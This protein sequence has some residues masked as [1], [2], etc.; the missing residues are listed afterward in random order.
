IVAATMWPPIPWPP[1]SGYDK[2]ASPPR[3]P[4]GRCASGRGRLGRIPA[5]SGQAGLLRV[6]VVTAPHA[7]T[8]AVA[9]AGV[10]ARDCHA[11]SARSFAGKEA[12]PGL[13]PA[14][15]GPELAGGCA[16]GRSPADH[17]PR[18]PAGAPAERWP[19]AARR[20]PD[21]R[22]DLAPR[23]GGDAFQRWECPR[24]PNP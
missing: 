16:W 18:L 11:L 15:H 23:R 12:L 4:R 6:D 2:I 13:V 24:E 22:A 5:R 21:T 17:R 14:R 19:R 9:T 20:D 10:E 1:P 7:S 3:E 8:V